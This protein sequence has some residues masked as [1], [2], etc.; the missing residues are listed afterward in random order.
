MAEIVQPEPVKSGSLAQL[1]PPPVHIARLKR[2]AHRR[3]KDQ[4]VIL[5]GSAKR[6]AFFVLPG[7]VPL[8]V[9]RGQLRDD[10]HPQRR[11]SL[12]L[13]ELERATCALKGPADLQLTR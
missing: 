7:P 13:N 10:Q 9:E 6:A 12:R 2:S 4:A 1:V 8:K 5:P 3:S 11:G